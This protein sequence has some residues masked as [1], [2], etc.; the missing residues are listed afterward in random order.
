MELDKILKFI[1]TQSFMLLAKQSSGNCQKLRCRGQNFP[2]LFLFNFLYFRGHCDRI[3]ERHLR[4]Y[5]GLAHVLAAEF[6]GLSFVIF[7][8]SFLS[9]FPSSCKSQ[10]ILDL[11]AQIFSVSDFSRYYRTSCKQMFWLTNK[12][13]D[14]VHFNSLIPQTVTIKGMEKTVQDLIQFDQSTCI[15]L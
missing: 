2:W 7:E 1:A 3:R 8:L 5:Y 14:C 10:Q 6:S 4:Y 12:V 15:L 11:R 9:R 13:K